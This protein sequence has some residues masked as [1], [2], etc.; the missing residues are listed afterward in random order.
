MSD[1]HETHQYVQEKGRVDSEDL[2]NFVASFVKGG[3]E[4]FDLE[5][6][7]D[8]ALMRKDI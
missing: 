6:E 4:D 2:M 7:S 5:S 3:T 8:D 1:L